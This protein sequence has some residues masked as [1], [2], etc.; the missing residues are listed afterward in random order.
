MSITLQTFLVDLLG[1]IDPFKDVITHVMIREE[2][3]GI[4]A[5]AKARDGSISLQAKSKGE[6]PEFTEKACLGSLPYL[7][8]AL[9]STYMKDG[10][11]KLTYG[12]S[13]NGSDEVLRSIKLTGAS[14]F[15]VFYQA[16][17]PFINQL[18]RIKLPTTLNWP[19]AFA[20]DEEFIG[21]FGE[22][23]RFS[24]LAPKAGTERDDIFQLVHTEAGIE[25]IFGDKHHQ[26]NVALSATVEAN[27]RT[28]KTNAYFSISKFKAIL[29]FVGKGAAIGYLSDKAV[30][31]D[32]E[33]AQ[34]EYQFVT[35]SKKV[36]A[37]DVV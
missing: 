8:G 35:A 32:T 13:S 17:D 30:R 15:N 31:V 10:D 36:K 2:D 26:S 29:R 19:V 33:T 28:E 21:H 37:N 22:I 34:A 11:L 3:G 23:T 9:M 6:I 7:R 4:K 5:A 24:A 12:K 14:G 27:S 20:I 25:G 1:A 18:N 16:V